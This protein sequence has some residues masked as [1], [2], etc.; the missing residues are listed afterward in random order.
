M[1]SLISNLPPKLSLYVLSAANGRAMLSPAA[2]GEKD[3]RH[4][5]AGSKLPL[6]ASLTE[7]LSLGLRRALE[8]GSKALDAR[9]TA[10][11]LA[12]VAGGEEDAGILVDNT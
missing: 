9:A 1:G 3:Q 11:A 6:L 7:N 2:P 12:A 4:G 5:P 10:G 8:L